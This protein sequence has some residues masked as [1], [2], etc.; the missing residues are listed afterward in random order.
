MKKFKFLSVVSLIAAAALTACSSTS[1]T[2]NNSQANADTKSEN[3]AVETEYND[4]MQVSYI[5]VG[6][7]DSEF[8]ELPNGQ[9]L[10][11][12]AGPNDA[13]SNVVDYIKS[14]GY[15]SIDY[16][17][18]THPHEDHIGGMDDVINAFDIGD[19]Y[20]P[21]ASTDTKTYENLLDAISEKNLVVFTAHDGVSLIDND[22]LSVK[23]VAPVS[24]S[25]DDLNNYSAVIR[26]EYGETSFL[27]TGDAEDVSEEEITDNVQADVLKVGHHGSDSS[28]TND[29]LERVNPSIAVISC[30][31]DNKYGHPAESTVKK[32]ND[33][34]IK[35]LRT[36][37]LG[38]IIISSDGSEVSLVQPTV[39]ADGEP[40]VCFA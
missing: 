24:D 28:T 5:Y 39:G 15:T 29:F 9:T 35:V 19:V 21:R 12:D 32:L 13:G 1:A 23:M 10:L 8:I 34:G 4:D 37:E 30:G 40:R 22:N 3:N 14:L 27:F 16:V 7:G 2:F 25:Y 33:K 31:K 20:M 38:T 17:V 6:Q 26:I 36:D 11:I 18:A